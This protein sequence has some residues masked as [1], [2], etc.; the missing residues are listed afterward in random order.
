MR[1]KIYPTDEERW[2]PQ[3]VLQVSSLAAAPDSPRLSF[4]PTS[5]SPFLFNVDDEDGNH[6]FSFTANG[7][8]MEN[9]LFFADQFL[10]I[11]TQVPA[12]TVINGFGI[13]MEPF[14]LS[15][16]TTFALY[17]AEPDGVREQWNIYSSHP[18]ATVS[19]PFLGS[20]PRFRSFGL[21]LL[22]SN[23]MDVQTPLRIERGTL[24]FHTIGGIIDMFIIAGPEPLD[25]VSRYHSLIGA[26]YLHPAWALGVGQCSWEYFSV[27]ELQ[28][29]VDGYDAAGIPL[30]VMWTD[31]TTMHDFQDFSLEPVLFE[32]EDMRAFISRLRGEGRK[33]ATILDPGQRSSDSNEYY[34]A[35]LDAPLD[36]WAYVRCPADDA[37]IISECWPG[38]VAMPDFTSEAAREMWQ[39]WIRDFY[40]SEDGA[41]FDGLWI[42][43][44]DPALF[45]S[46]ECGGNDMCTGELTAGME[47]LNEPPYT[48]GHSKNM[49][50]QT[51]M[52]AARHN[53]STHYN[54]HNMYSFYET[55]ATLPV[56]EELA[57]GENHDMAS[58][59][60]LLSRGS[61]LGSGRMAGSW[62]GDNSAE[63]IHLASSIWMIQQ[64]NLHGISLA[65]PDTCGFMGDSN[66]E[67]CTR[68]YALGVHYPLLRNHYSIGTSRQEPYVWGDATSEI[69]AS[70]VKLRY[71]LAPYMY[72]LLERV[73]RAGGMLWYPAYYEFPDLLPHAAL[74]ANTTMVGPCIFVA[75]VLDEGLDAIDI[76][77]PAGAEW[78][79]LTGGLYSGNITYAAPIE[80]PAPTFI[81]AGA[82]LP[83][84]FPEETLDATLRGDYYLTVALPSGA[85]ELPALDATPFY[86]DDGLSVPIFDGGR[87]SYLETGLSATFASATSFTLCNTIA[88]KGG[89]AYPNYFVEIELLGAAPGAAYTLDGYSG[90]LV[91]DT[92]GVINGVVLSPASDWCVEVAL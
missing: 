68:W 80:D 87:G 31:I 44:N 48:V 12:G 74:F 16:D 49:D 56:L 70:F 61:F 79:D 39:G 52:F 73:H 77:L 64:A 67:L 3:D 5:V 40:S 63:Y 50:A 36:T 45:C 46:G 17:N 91:G 66:E 14:Q 7:A 76:V 65:G 89:S 23:A 43:M 22:N 19:A 90:T 84:H 81:R 37:P 10:Q 75:P 92:N 69:I 25:V 34:A 6:L 57:A 33:Y 78:R 8:D 59:A 58:R 30:D 38:K 26:P 2:E 24:K 88:E 60:L 32:P 55:M 85:G 1:V 9:Q 11:S 15:E 35:M 47:L 4:V 13:R 53:L 27:D 62:L 54:V 28:E 20:D 18:F 82:I 42:D 71:S 41:P 72:S 29:V 86:F 83:R 51:L 21:M